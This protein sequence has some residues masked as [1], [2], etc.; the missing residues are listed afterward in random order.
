MMM[1]SGRVTLNTWVERPVYMGQG[2]DTLSKSA[3]CVTVVEEGGPMGAVVLKHLSDHVVDVGIG[4]PRV[5]GFV[6]SKESAHA[7]M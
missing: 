7:C 4:S 3:P 2:S 5:Q 6:F 1:N